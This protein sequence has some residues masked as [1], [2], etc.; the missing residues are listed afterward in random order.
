MQRQL[1]ASFVVLAFHD[2]L[3]LDSANATMDSPGG[4]FTEYMIEMYDGATAC[5]ALAVI[6]FAIE[7]TVSTLYKFVWDGLWCDEP[8]WLTR[9]AVTGRHPL[10]MGPS[11]RSCI[12]RLCFVGSTGT[13]ANLRSRKSNLRGAKKPTRRRKITA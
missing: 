5:E 2:A 10:A 12:S 13:K 4:R 3:G 1:L 7:E 11:R 9:T 8:G 6:G